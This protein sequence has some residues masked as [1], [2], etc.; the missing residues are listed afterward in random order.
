MELDGVGG[1]F[2]DF[3]DVLHGTVLEGGQERLL[4]QLLGNVPATG[5]GG[6]EGQDAPPLLAVER[7]EIDGIGDAATVVDLLLSPSPASALCS[8]VLSVRWTF[9]E[10]LGSAGQLDGVAGW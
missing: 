9:A 10:R 7:L 8:K 2:E 3:G 5:E 1:A 4:A 6:G